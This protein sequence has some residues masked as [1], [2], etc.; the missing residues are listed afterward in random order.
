MGAYPAVSGKVLE[1]I[2]GDS[3]H[4]MNDEW[5]NFI[6]VYYPR[7]EDYLH[8]VPNLPDEIVLQ[9]KNAYERGIQFPCSETD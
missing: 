4:S 9:R 5:D 2:E 3:E 6:L 1:I 7:Q 8:L